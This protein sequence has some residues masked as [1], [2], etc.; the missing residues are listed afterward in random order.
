MTPEKSDDGVDQVGKQ[1][2]EGK[3]YDDS[4]SGINDSEYNRKEQD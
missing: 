3:D 2:S 4:S 1:D